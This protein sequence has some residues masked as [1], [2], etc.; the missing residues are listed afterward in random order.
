M[1][2]LFLNCHKHIFGISVHCST[3]SS[4]LHHGMKF[5]LNNIV[6][7]YICGI[8]LHCIRVF[9]RVIV[10]DDNILYPILFY[11][12]IF[13]YSRTV[14]IILLHPQCV[15]ILSVQ[16]ALQLLEIICLSNAMVINYCHVILYAWCLSFTTRSSTSY[17]KKNKENITSCVLEDF[18]R[19]DLSDTSRSEQQME[20]LS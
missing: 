9:L 17:S 11:H 8:E 6:N 10:T 18:P 15:Y 16:L 3:C 13:Y 7:I 19:N 4:T 14:K 1:M 5:D 20:N 2:I 12:D